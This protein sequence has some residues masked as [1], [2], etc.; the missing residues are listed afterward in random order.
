MSELLLPVQTRD[1]TAGYWRHF[2]HSSGKKNTICFIVTLFGSVDLALW[3]R[4]WLNL[5]AWSMHR[6]TQHK[7][8]DDE[9]PL[10]LVCRHPVEVSLRLSHKVCFT[11]TPATDLH[12]NIVPCFIKKTKNSH[13]Q[14]RALMY[15][16]RLLVH[17]MR[18]EVPVLEAQVETVNWSPSGGK[19]DEMTDETDK[20][21][22]DKLKT[23]WGCAGNASWK[24]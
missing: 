9:G 23:W 3:V 5:C 15:P 1:W 4:R 17:V 16:F 12:K 8:Q 2:V 20:H 6:S 24:T 13:D 18:P 11:S 14:Q 19:L 7:Q 10:G 21:R 22:P